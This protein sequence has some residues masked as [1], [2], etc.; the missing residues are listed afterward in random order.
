MG[1]RAR[2]N[3]RAQTTIEGYRTLCR[4][5][6]NGTSPCEPPMWT[7]P[8]NNENAERWLNRF[9]NRDVM[10]F[11]TVKT[12]L[13]RDLLTVTP[14]MRAE[15]DRRF[16]EVVRYPGRRPWVAIHV[17]RGDKVRKHEADLTEARDYVRA[18]VAAGMAD[19]QDVFIMSDDP[20]AAREVEGN[21]TLFGGHRRTTFHR[22]FDPLRPDK[23][24][25]AAHQRA[26]F[27]HLLTD[28]RVML[29]SDVFVGTH[30]SN[31]GITVC[32]A[33]AWMRCM[34][35][36]NPGGQYFWNGSTDKVRG[37]RRLAEPSP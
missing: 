31:I 28:V 2:T 16:A 23:T 35:A 3:P 25:V 24:T 8:G 27:L 6:A 4:Y 11:R 22:R 17:R 21:W 37:R 36:E 34:D 30:T 5:H 26:S 1:A 15:I 10:L 20:G 32:T 9:R 33:R 14:A 13:Y 18:C 19:V 29:E 12:L 7:F